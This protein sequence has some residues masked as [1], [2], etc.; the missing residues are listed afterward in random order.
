MH[1]RLGK[2]YST[3]ALTDEAYAMTAGGRA[4]TWSGARI[5]ALQALLQ[6]YWVGGAT[7]GAL[8][9]TLIPERVTGLDFAM[10]ALFAVLALDA[11][12][13]RR[14][15]LPTPVLA[16]LSALAAR[17]LAPAEL[18]PVAFALFTGALLVRYAARVR[19]GPRRA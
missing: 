4:R 11:V 17:L 16:L 6:V 18:L 7:A 5:L 3:F 13:E 10:T 14:G 15:D 2:A 1:G 12:T 9:G 8:L 19:K